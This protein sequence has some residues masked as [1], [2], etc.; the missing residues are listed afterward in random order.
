MRERG[1]SVDHTTLYRWVMHYAKELKKRAAWYGR[2]HGRS[3]FVD[4]TYIKVKGKWRYL[5]RVINGYGDTID[6]YLSHRR[7]SKSARRFLAKALKVNK[8]WVPLTINTDQ[9]P[10]YI[11]VVKSLKRSHDGY[12]DIKHRRIKYHNNRIRCE[13]W[14][15][16][17]G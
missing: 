3:W 7:N 9:N 11:Q 16:K 8:D 10:A 14:R 2:T 12:T 6:F 5:Y 1:L 15:A 4:E 13:P 17:R